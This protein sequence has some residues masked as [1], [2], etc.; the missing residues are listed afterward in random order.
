MRDQEREDSENCAAAPLH[1][2][3]AFRRLLDPWA[4]QSIYL[5][6][7]CGCLGR[8]CL[9]QSFLINLLVGFTD[10]FGLNS[11]LPLVLLS[12]PCSSAFGFWRAL[13]RCRAVMRSQRYFFLSLRARTHDKRLFSWI[14]VLII[15]MI[16]VIAYLDQWEVQ[17]WLSTGDRSRVFS[18][19]LKRFANLFVPSGVGA[20]V[21]LYA[22]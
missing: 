14:R 1:F 13:Q 2:S 15:S 11:L 9:Q 5:S 21:T 8:L 20:V 7:H 6:L 18:H 17:L 12:F 3:L 4:V 22:A 16:L 19:L 10:V